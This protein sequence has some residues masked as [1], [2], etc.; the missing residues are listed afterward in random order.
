MTT[1]WALAA[2]ALVLGGCSGCGAPPLRVE[3]G[4]H[5]E[6]LDE[7]SGLAT[8]RRYPGTFWTHNDSGDAAR[9]F[10]VDQ[11]GALKG[12]WQVNGA[13]N[14]DWE[15]IASDDAGHLW[16]ADIGNNANARQDLTLYRVPEPDPAGGDGV[17]HVDRLVR[18]R[19]PDQ[20]A[21]PPLEGER[22]FDA[23][24]LFWAP[25]AHLGHPTLYI[26]TKHRNADLE[27][28]L[29]RVDQ[30]SDGADITL[31]HIST[32][33]V[34]G[35]P[36]RYGGM[37]TG[38]AA[39]PDGRLLAVLTYHG[40]FIFERP[41]TGDDYLRHLR[42]R[43]DFEQDVTEQAEAITWYGGALLFG[44]EQRRIWTIDAPMTEQA[45]RFPP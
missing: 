22:R 31:T 14:I 4:F 39:T 38:A 8:S 2:L 1:H 35:D 43:I 19:Y 15:D 40:I 44:N 30:L 45:A 23:E 26:L 18:V 42:G 9:I 29:Y 33:H 13:R 41:A 5:A 36:E 10:A 6:A 24:A 34:G 20:S 21:F 25:S 16:I 32:V 28:D 17:V 12:I 3:P 11:R 7:V 27:T 37:V